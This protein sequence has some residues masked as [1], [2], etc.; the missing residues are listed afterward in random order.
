ME[1]VHFA[2]LSPLLGLG[3]THTV[4]TRLIEKP[5]IVDFHLAKR[6]HPNDR[7]QNGIEYIIL[8]YLD[9]FGAFF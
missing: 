1:N 4:H 8:F 3:A 9:R 2:F 6:T 5:I 7:Q